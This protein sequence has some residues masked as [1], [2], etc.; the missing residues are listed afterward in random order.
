MNISEDQ[1][2][3]AKAKGEQLISAIPLIPEV[4][5]IGVEPYL[6][7]TG[8]RAL[9]LTFHLRRGVAVD[10]AFFEKFH[11]FKA[12]V[13]TRILHSDLERFPYTRLEKAA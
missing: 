7:H 8:D 5:A 9:Q 4:E 12:L 10:D 2:Q 13:Q 11:P 6:D 3:I 1:D